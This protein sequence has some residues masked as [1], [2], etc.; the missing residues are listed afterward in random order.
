MLSWLHKG[1]DIP[2]LMSAPATTAGPVQGYGALDPL[3]PSEHT[4]GAAP[5]RCVPQTPGV[6]HIRVPPQPYRRTP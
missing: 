6:S 5:H 1:S 4:I 2:S 3:P